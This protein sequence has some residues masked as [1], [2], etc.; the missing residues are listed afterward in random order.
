MKPNNTL[1]ATRFVLTI[2]RTYKY[3]CQ[4]HIFILHIVYYIY[5]LIKHFS[6]HFPYFS[7]RKNVKQ[8]N[9][10]ALQYYISIQL[11]YYIY[12]SN[13]TFSL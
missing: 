5:C 7:Y 4:I 8:F 10:Q 2:F 6:S 1:H 11:D 3:V 13:K 9:N 12:M